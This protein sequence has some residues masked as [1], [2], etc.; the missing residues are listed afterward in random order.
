V[1]DA[2][3]ALHRLQFSART[4]CRLLRVHPSGRIVL[5]NETLRTW[6]DQGDDELLGKRL[7]DLL[8]VAGRVFYETHFAPLLRMQG[9]FHEV[10]LDLVR[11]DRSRL[12]VLANAS[13]R[14]NADG[15]VVESRITL[16]QATSRRKYERELFEAHGSGSRPA[17]RWNVSTRR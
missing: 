2:F 14:V 17:G 15:E 8:S 12:S 13:Q 9:Y 11:R 16:F 5:V 10:A 1:K 7:L 3:I 6:L 4:M